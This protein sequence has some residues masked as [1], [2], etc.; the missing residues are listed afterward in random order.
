MSV[1]DLDLC[2]S[3]YEGKLSL[4]KKAVQEDQGLVRK[5]DK[6]RR[7]ALH[8][9]CSSGQDAVAEFL[10]NQGSKVETKQTFMACSNC[11]YYMYDKC[12][13]IITIM[14]HNIIHRIKTTFSSRETKFRDLLQS[15]FSQSNDFFNYIRD[16]SFT[17]WTEVII[18]YF[19]IMSVREIFC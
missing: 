8:W 18:I 7:T 15:R 13:A 3:A 4:V 10:L 1:S 6:N 16:P 12:A 2:N 19:L 17:I 5:K 14:R 11:A 9:A